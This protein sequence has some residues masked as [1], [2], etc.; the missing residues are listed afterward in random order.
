V[1]GDELRTLGGNS[2]AINAVAFS[3]D[4]HTL[5]L[6]SNTLKHWDAATGDE[7]RAFRPS[8]GFEGND[9]AVA[10]APDNRTLVSCSDQG[11]LKVWNVATGRGLL[12]WNAIDSRDLPPITAQHGRP[13]AL[14]PDGKTILS[15]GSTLKL[16]DATT[17]REV[18]RMEQR[19][20]LVVS[21]AFS[22][23][24]RTAVSA[25]DRGALRLWEVASGRELRTLSEQHALFDTAASINAV[26]FS[27]DGRTIIS[28]GDDRFLRFWDV[29]SGR[30]LRSRGQRNH[31]MHLVALSPDG[32]TIVAGYEKT[33]R[34]WEAEGGRE[35]RRDAPAL[36]GCRAMACSPMRC[37]RGSARAMP[38]AT[39]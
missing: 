7:L 19:D 3:P 38:T 6:A 36:E 32:R 24:G 9:I 35:L 4:G 5:A 22:P 29:A 11:R 15:G 34:L 21:L 13:I 2:G 10:F 8:S 25:S 26:V 27:P 12:S 30:E 20:E 1:S 33:L 14:S 31:W 39:G 23:D 17:G 16:W 18:G 28:G 37:W